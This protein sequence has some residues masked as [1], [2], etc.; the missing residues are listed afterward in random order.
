L[1]WVSRTTNSTALDAPLI[2]YWGLCEVSGSACTITYVRVEQIAEDREEPCLQA[3]VRI[4]AL[5]V[6]QSPQ[7]RVLDQIVCLIGAAGERDCEGPQVR[8]RLQHGISHR[9]G[10]GSSH[11][12]Q[13]KLFEC[14]L[15]AL[16]HDLCTGA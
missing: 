12:T 4:K 6:A 8:D 9:R 7:D 11:L 1:I 2:L 5:N 3:A 15:K 14:H 10:K 16:E 13:R